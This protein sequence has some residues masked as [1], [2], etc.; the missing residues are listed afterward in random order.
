V[1]VYRD[2]D[3]SQ[4]AARIVARFPR[5]GKNKKDPPTFANGKFDGF[6]ICPLNPMV[7]P[8]ESP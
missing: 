7:S 8:A 3:F 2:G 6:E 4:P 5:K 1:E